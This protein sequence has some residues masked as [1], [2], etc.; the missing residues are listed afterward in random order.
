MLRIKREDYD[1]YEKLYPGIIKTIMH[2]E[3]AVLPA[4]SKCG[5]TNTA[6]VNVRIIGLTIHIAGATTKF[7]L[8]PNGPRPGMYFCNNCKQYFD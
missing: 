5:S 8:I 4:C 1:A 3:N 7:H 6:D 2:F